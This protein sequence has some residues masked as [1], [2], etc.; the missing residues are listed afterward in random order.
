MA[1]HGGADGREAAP[2]EVESIVWM[3]EARRFETPDGEAFLEYRLPSPAVMDVVHTYVP[4]SKRGRGL[5][6][7]LC[8][9]AFAC[10]SSPPAPTSPT[11]TS[12]AIRR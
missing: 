1:N 12:L 4:R 7:R 9:A 5:A 6:A 11:R 3:E 10:A 8:D 2:P